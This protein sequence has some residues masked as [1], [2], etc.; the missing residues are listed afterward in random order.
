MHNPQE[1][2]QLREQLE[3]APV[4]GIHE[5]LATH[6]E[7]GFVRGDLYHWIS[8]LNHFDDVMAEVCE[9]YSLTGL[10]KTDFDN[11]TQ[12]TLVAI[13]HFSR[14][15][16]ENCINRNL[17]S[18]VD[19]LDGLLNTSDPDVLECTLRLLL[20]TSQRWSY[21]RDLKANQA[22]MSGRLTTLADPWHIKKDLVSSVEHG[23]EE[24]IASH[25]NEFRLMA[26]HESTEPL[27]KHAG[28]VR[29]QFFRTAEDVQQLESESATTHANTSTTERPEPNQQARPV[30]AEST[31]EPRRRAGH[32]SGEGGGASSNSGADGGGTSSHRKSARKSH[33]Q[34]TPGRMSSAV[35]EGL[36]SI[37]VPV[38][39]LGIDASAS[40]S[41]QVRQALDKL[42]VKH[43]VPSIHHY[44][45]RHRILVALAFATGNS[46]LRYM[47]LRSRVYAAAV[48]SQLMNEQ[49]FKNMFLSREPSFTADI[50]GV[51]QPEAHAPLSV[52][53]AVFM[54]LE[55]LLKQR[56]E[57]S[58]AYVALNASA[59]HGVLMFILRKAFTN[60]DAP[61]VYPYEFMSA[62]YFFLTGMA[63]NMNG[64]QLLVSAGVVPIFVS[65]LKH[66]HPQ[67]LR[68]T[69]RVAKLLDYL[70]SSTNSTFSAFCGANGIATLVERMHAEVLRAVE[71]SNADPESTKDL[72]SPVTLPNFPDNP[73]QLYRRREILPAEQIYLLK[74]LFKLLS[75]LAQQTSYQDRLRN[76][77]ET[78]LPATLRTVLAHPAA[79]G[80]NTYGLAISISAMLVHNEPTSL[81][82][83]QEAR[84]PD[85]MLEE[86]ER[87]LPYNSDVII[88][89]PGALGAFCLNDAGMEQ[90][91][92]SKIVGKVLSTFSD[93]DFIRVLQEGDVTG[94]FGASLDEFMR[95]F[96]V[97]KEDTMDQIIA[98]LKDVR[99][100]G[101][102]DSPLLKLNPGNTFLLRSGREEELKT[103]LD[104]FY[105][106]MLESV[107][108]F[109]EGLLEQRAHSKLFMERGGWEL[110]VQAIRSPL[111]PFGF[112]KSRTFESLHGLSSTLL[113]A[114]QEGVLKV[115]F[116]VLQ[117][118]IQQPMIVNVSGQPDS[119]SMSVLDYLA[120][121]DPA[122]MAPAEYTSVHEKL[123]NTISSAGAIALITYLINGSGGGLMT[124]CVKDITDVMP[125]GEFV[126]LVGTVCRA[127]ADAIQKA[128]TIE[129]AI[130]MLPESSD[131]IKADKKSKGKEPESSAAQ[132]QTMDVDQGG[133]AD[134]AV[135]A[136]VRANYLNLGETVISFTLEAGDF[137]ECM[138]NSLGLGV[139][140]KDNWSTP[141][142]TTQLADVLVEFTLKMLELSRGAERTVV[143]AQL[144]DQVMVALMKT[145]VFARHR[146]Y[147]KLRIFN[148]F[149][150]QGGPEQFCQVLGTMWDWAASL[151]QDKLDPGSKATAAEQETERLRKILDNT[152]ESMLSI[153]SFILDG[154]PIVECPEYPT[155]CHDHDA[156][157]CWFRPGDLVVSLRL[158]ALPTLQRIWES[159][160]LVRGNSN[161]MQAFI[162]CLGP[163]LS[164]QQ[165]TRT[166][167]S[168]IGLRRHLPSLLDGGRRASQT[169]GRGSE[170]HTPIPLL[171]R[172]MGSVERSSPLARTP[173]QPQT[174]T[175]P[176][177][178]Y[179]AELEAMGFSSEEASAALRRHSNSIA[180]AA[181]DLLSATFSGRSN[182]STQDASSNSAEGSSG[183][184]DANQDQA[185]SEN[186]GE[187]RNDDTT[188]SNMQGEQ[189]SPETEAMAVDERSEGE[190]SD[191]SNEAAGAPEALPAADNS[192]SER[193]SSIEPAG[194]EPY[195][196]PE[197]RAAREAEEDERRKQLKQ[198]RDKMRVGIAPRSVALVDKFKDQ[199]VTHVCGVLELVLCKNESAP[200]M[201]VLRNAFTPL[202]D[203]VAA[204]NANDDVEERLAAHAYLWAVLLSNGQL[205][206]EI[207]PHVGGLGSHLL[208]ALDAATLR[209][210]RAPKWFA[211]LL[212]VVEL[213]L[214][215]DKE[216]QPVKL[217]GRDDLRRVAK[218]KL[219][220]LPPSSD[221]I[222][223]SIMASPPEESGGG[224]HVG[225]LLDLLSGY[226]H[227]QQQ[228]RSAFDPVWGGDLDATEEAEVEAA[229]GAQEARQE[230]EPIFGEG[231]RAELQRLAMR[232]FSAP[233]PSF[234]PAE[235]NALLRL[236]VVLTRNSAFAIEFLESGSLAHV[237]RTMRTFQ[238]NSSTSI[239]ESAAKERTPLGFVNAIMSIT[240]EQQQELR[241]ERTLVVHVLRHAIESRPVLQL[242]MENLLQG[243]FERPQLSSTDTNT[244]VRG[245]LAYALRDPELYNKVV[246][247]RCYLPNYN[248]E[249]RI[250]WI[251][252]AW[253]S[254]K[255]LEEEEVDRFEELPL[256]E[257]PQ[258]P[259]ASGSEQQQ[260]ATQQQLPETE[261]RQKKGPEQQSDSEFLEY[262]A[263]KKGEAP[264]EPY[265]LDIESE[266]LAC[267]IVE[268]IV[269]EVLS[270]RPLISTPAVSRTATTLELQPP[271]T[272]S[273][274]RS[275][276][277]A[278]LTSSG[279]VGAGAAQTPGT[280]IVEDSPETIAY[281]C[282]LMQCLSELI[283]SF[284]FT[285]QAIFVARSSLAGILSPRK[286]K[287]KGKS[288]ALDDGGTQ[289]QQQ[290]PS[291]RVRSP[292]ISHLV[293]DLIVR[294]AVTSAKPPKKG[295]NGEVVTEGTELEQVMAIAGQQ[296]AQKR[297]QLSRSV[298]FWATALLSTIC[299][300]HQ[301]GWTTTVE[302]KDSGDASEITMASLPGNY[303]RALSAARQLTL[304]HVVR[305]FRECLSATAA[306]VGGADVIYA[307][308]MALANVTYKLVIARP[309]THGR[310]ADT[311]SGVQQGQAE[312]PNA[313]KKMVLERGVLD[314][315]TAASSR[316]DLNHP[317]SRDM[318]NVFL[319]PMEHLAKA[320]VKISREAVLTAWEESGQEKMPLAAGQRGFNM[321]LLEDDNALIDSDEDIPPDLYENSAL[322]LHQ[323]QRMAAGRS[324]EAYD[325]DGLMEEDYEEDPYDDDN[326]S[327][328]DLDTDDEMDEDIFLDE[329]AAELADED[330]MAMDRMHE[331]IVGESEDGSEA[332]E[333]DDGSA[334]DESDA[335]D[336]D[337]DDADTHGGVFHF[338]LEGDD[339]RMLRAEGDTVSLYE[340]DAESDE[341]G[342]NDGSAHDHEDGWDTELSDTDMDVLEAV[343]LHHHHHPQARAARRSH[344]PSANGDV[345]PADGDVAVAAADADE[346]SGSEG[347]RSD[348]SGESGEEADSFA[349]DYSETFDLTMEEI[350]EYGNTEAIRSADLPSFIL[351]TIAVNIGDRRAPA[352]LRGARPAGLRAGRPLGVINGIP[353]GVGGGG[354]LVG[355]DR[356][357]ADFGL[358][359]LSGLGRAGVAV[360]GIGAGGQSMA[361]PLLE[362]GARADRTGGLQAR[363]ERV[364]RSTLNGPLHATPDDVYELGQSLATRLSQALS[365]G[366]RPAYT[367]RLVAGPS[368]RLGASPWAQAPAEPSGM[369]GAALGE[370]GTQAPVLE[371]LVRMSR[372][373]AAIDGYV[374]LSTAERWQEEAR[375]L[376]GTG[377]S[378]CV[379]RIANALLNALIPD[380]ICQR[381]L[382]SRYH[383]ELM[384]RTAISDRRRL[385]R[386]DVGRHL[387]EARAFAEE[388]MRVVDRDVGM[389]VDRVGSTKTEDQEGVSGEEPVPAEGSEREP[390]EGSG[391]E[392]IVEGSEEAQVEGLEAEP[393]NAQEENSVRE[394]GETRGEN[395]A[396]ESEESQPPEPVYVTVEGE[397]ID[398]T[399]MGI[400]LEFL[401]ALP[402]DLR[403]EVIDDRRVELRAER[404][405]E[406]RATPSGGGGTGSDEHDGFMREFLDALPMEIREEVLESGPL[407]RQ[408]L[409]QEGLIQHR[410]TTAAPRT[411]QQQQEQ[412]QQQQSPMSTLEAAIRERVRV[413]AQWSGPRLLQPT[414]SSEDNGNAEETR[415]REK[416]R[417][418]IA[419]RDI[420]VQLL[421][422]A[423]LVAL[424]RF[425]FLPNHALS[426]TLVAR[427]VQCLCENGRTR[428]QFIHLM[429]AILDSDAASLSDVDTV[430]RHALGAAQPADAPEADAPGATVLGTPAVAQFTA[431]L[432][433][434]QS[435]AFAFPLSALQA[436]VAASVP[437]Q[438]CLEALHN[439]AAHNARAAMH[440]LVE[441]HMLRARDSAG[442]SRFPLVHL[443]ALLDKPLYYGHGG[444]I[445]ELLMQLLSTV[446]KPLGG[447]VR[448]SQQAQRES[449]DASAGESSSRNAPPLPGIPGDA[450]RAI[451]NVIAAGEC[452]SRTFQHTLSLIQNLSHMPGVLPIIADELI[453]RA[454]DLSECVCADISQLLDELQPLEP[455]DTTS[456]LATDS[457]DDGAATRTPVPAALLDR[458]RDITLAQFSPAS[459]HQSR[460][461]RLL[462]AIDYISTTVARR[463]DERQRRAESQADGAAM[464]VDST[465]SNADES[466]AVELMH[467]R[468]LSLGHDSHF[469][470]LWEATGRCLRHT[471]AHPELA[472][473]STVLLP[474]IES[475][476]VVF[477]P[478]VG[479]KNRVSVAGAA[480]AAEQPPLSASVSLA[481]ASTSHAPMSASSLQAP[482]A[483]V[484]Y[485]QNFT[486]RH[487]KVLNTLVR[488]NPGL[489]S[490]SFSLLVYNPHVLDFDNKRSYFNQR[491]HD[492][493]TSTR[494]GAAAPLGNLLQVNVRRPTVFVDSF[495]QF[496]GK[497]GDEIKRAR[498]NVKFRDEE[499]VDAGGV[500][501]EWFQVL[502]R[503]MFNPNYALFMPS[504]AGRVTYQPNPQSWANPEHLLY[505]KFVG[506][507][508]GKAIVDQRVLDAYFTRSFYKHI[509]GRSVDYRDMEAIDPSYYKSLEWILENDITDVFE[510]T[511]SIEVDDFGQHRIVDLIP[512]GQKITVA[513]ENK[514]EYVR[515][516][517]EQRLYGAIKDQI[518]AFLTGF[519][520][521][522]PKDLI[523]I[524]NEQELELLISGMP[525]V[526]VDDWR[527]NTEYHGGY[528]S[529]SVQIQW[530]WR[531]VRMFDHEERAKLLQFVTGT[532]KVPLEGF[533]Q[534]Q[535]NQGVQ[536]FQIHKDFSS[537]TRLPT[538]HTCFNQLDLPL[539]ESFESLK[540][541]LLLA[542]SECSTG[543]G[544]V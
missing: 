257:T 170:S 358:P 39:D 232:F 11:D 168:R 354:L 405:A 412:Q 51:L 222:D 60:V 340:S 318:L 238:S 402:D 135:E 336:D 305:A 296:V 33:S 241:Q 99:A 212:L 66:T 406:T 399:D 285:L 515:L 223:D 155:L 25:T 341:A 387:R 74:E 413:G 510:E 408:L 357:V 127:Y 303:G 383:V 178:E 266:K 69:G 186:N 526:D 338:S 434:Q 250:S 5:V 324:G 513:E 233:V 265:E 194:T 501:R 46:E 261:Q 259:E 488:N 283:A 426:S 378:S 247:E 122:S 180:R 482:A 427:L 83:I 442:A 529:S 301:E 49:E 531:A 422:R 437:A 293:H 251:T 539:Y 216:P 138:S 123:H 103:F 139:K 200:I 459:S 159:S 151:P 235:L 483:G 115:L 400:D 148:L 473:V 505:F 463:L 89:I 17:Y 381:L 149:V 382:R 94:S 479:E 385:E 391:V 205:M 279:A 143:G 449:A 167:S 389:A 102:A 199:A 316:L 512:D 206:D 503:Q 262:L 330:A 277:Y 326:S 22:M 209:E 407:Q 320:A 337:D 193:V 334:G 13:L 118:C 165:E 29:Y 179:V 101:A 196:K 524:F 144:V 388:A 63:N 256:E 317:L 331:D 158:C 54:A 120:L 313:L 377:S 500:S 97:V 147:L 435:P 356:D 184:Q 188:S 134:T 418:K 113:D 218:R 192:G 57:V 419:S 445:A 10:Q 67:Q 175:E 26:R 290:Q 379:P 415:I 484:A 64:G 469:L 1:I 476:M 107:T 297:G 516:V 353:A 376:F 487:K 12:K 23:A 171:A 77:V 229:D 79:F 470:P 208:Q 131:S 224:R 344:A 215:R 50:I 236:V 362:R 361:H 386:K 343:H 96:P 292:L 520:D 441:H 471:S 150:E 187:T 281:R 307:R 130:S 30:A 2:Q 428:A 228:S 374:P 322:G 38:H 504:A 231:E 291:L 21:Q 87:H 306:G 397:R 394:S 432:V 152:L 219:T 533:A 366:R 462:M 323:N 414:G 56:S 9:K 328:S 446:T 275:T 166:A 117:E 370:V 478:I 28:I 271:T 252:L 86:L 314:L 294:E 486:E 429:L 365:A 116:K 177:P 36:V 416:R 204:E 53:T 523:Q 420:A 18:S 451:V 368:N 42:V 230:S 137:I 536:R 436:D 43:K 472:H 454:T 260:D 276:S 202:L 312:G 84:I 475:F 507:I 141:K 282:F 7:W 372:A 71:T 411:R 55:S 278:M 119:E 424:A 8:V 443:L 327:V 47:L 467:L 213:L 493:V 425:I 267:R 73:K 227:Q 367:H 404:R 310:G 280:A 173:A 62:L 161:L 162:A 274:Q 527:N 269:D 349:N 112:V 65:A 207:Y 417:R 44:E 384:R 319:R 104:D 295:G 242:V 90:V 214:R 540:S 31:P 396:R 195:N 153:L 522:I 304:D 485:F 81:P 27:K 444:S 481:S 124:R 369:V 19:R 176:N 100:M 35:S 287:G 528:N 498:I 375:M 421:S 364:A 491:L 335:A 32:T 460:L 95:H 140:P 126:K 61:P 348:E 110:V 142:I 333:D 321:D 254:S 519:H 461:L 248:G 133:P 474:L 468:S 455:N 85:T 433:Q 198:L 164:A 201:H 308:L 439:L 246:T 190:L 502:A 363:A 217:E 302:R 490:G 465:G 59:N 72:T 70:I 431:A 268:F 154:E 508:I 156:R 438:R 489:L 495:H 210:G 525:D 105:G 351:D 240:K 299:V 109:L 457:G 145:L 203:A 456:D 244:V 52:Q 409:E 538:A 181:N 298:T 225:Q 15:L 518:N 535:G 410:G 464:D 106:M 80:G 185:S 359:R 458:V 129:H 48:L 511:F 40:I 243:W 3:A 350:D 4:S 371:Q 41:E 392:H 37:H 309:I 245:T 34:L 390:A 128:V 450:L 221:S 16:L 76:L 496:A 311:S 136:Y 284:P 211:A 197:W 163:I 82:I 78:T 226:R 258:T 45:L 88:N 264:Y 360:G 289:H 108:T 68:S 477:K 401:L 342:S 160:L 345:S 169:S 329:D 453:R 423:E 440:F 398:I 255:L 263:K 499:G 339:E 75:H 544:F 92:K 530:F 514:A 237:L 543:F 492:D 509:L 325:E 288:L 132:L 466:L 352:G 270:L 347:E 541:N 506:R 114:S 497:T 532:S 300:R 355:R 430:I 393:N 534:L 272:P 373:A 380:A 189:A 315:L 6:Q 448:C 58:G 521:V 332:S 91:H 249:M 517:T 286:D 494:R 537:P 253:R 98:M 125:A 239:S 20:R 403:M 111:L 346:A 14:L 447:M 191:G 146:I 452:T 220:K 273:K 157:Q 542:I 121:V 174:T 24:S 395:P 182:R 183:A 172:A 480:A 234:A 93:P